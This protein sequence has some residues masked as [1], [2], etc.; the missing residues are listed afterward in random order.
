[1]EK[2]SS[3]I[4][5]FTAVSFSFTP[6]KYLADTTTI[7][8][9]KS[10]YLIEENLMVKEGQVLKIE[11]GCVLLFNPFCGLIVDGTLR[12]EGTLKKPV[13]FTTVNDTLYNDTVSTLPNPFDWNGILIGAKAK[14][15]SLSNFQ[16]TYSVYGIKSMKEEFTINNGTFNHNGQFHV[17]V[18]E[19]IKPAIDGVPYNY[20]IE[21]SDT[22]KPT[23]Q[24]QSSSQQS[25]TNRKPALLA[26]TG[27]ISLAAGGASTGLFIY[28]RKQYLDATAPS[29]LS[30]YKTTMI[31]TLSTAAAFTTAAA[32]LI[33][34]SIISKKNDNR[35]HSHNLLFVPV[36]ANYPGATII[37]HF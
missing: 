22:S 17:I 16:L 32:I 25:A 33:P 37:Y 35:K 19:T 20:G 11:E 9:D 4:L 14:H 24:S 5:L 6:L 23:L 12:I 26:A 2:L 1:M 36:C 10:P 29:K 28:S 27:L 3:L 15:I 21:P 13:V 31:T 30:H 18:N 8:A 7:S 34:A